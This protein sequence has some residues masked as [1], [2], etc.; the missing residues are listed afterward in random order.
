MSEKLN[1]FIYLFSSLLW[2][3]FGIIPSSK[4]DKCM[5]EFISN[6]GG[7]LFLF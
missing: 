7:I 4:A 6:S 1:G 3:E 2:L 5:K